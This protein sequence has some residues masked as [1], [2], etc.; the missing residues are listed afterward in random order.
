MNNNRHLEKVLENMED[1]YV[2][3]T[4]CKKYHRKKEQQKKV[5]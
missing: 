1:L 3:S 5:Q 2:G 4:P